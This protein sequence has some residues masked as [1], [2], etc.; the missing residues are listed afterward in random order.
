[1]AANSRPRGAGKERGKGITPEELQTIQL[2]HQRG[3]TPTEIAKA[4]GRGRA[5]VYR[6]IQRG[7]VDQ[8]AMDFDGDR[9]E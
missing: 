5:T 2:L 8:I 7:A 1:M 3:N 9:H 4:I 6:L